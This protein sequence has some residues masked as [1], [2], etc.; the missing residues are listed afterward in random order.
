MDL[1]HVASILRGGTLPRQSRIL[2]VGFYCSICFI[3]LKNIYF[4]PLALS[5][6][7]ANGR[8]STLLLL[9]SNCLATYSTAI[10]IL[11]PSIVNL[12]MFEHWQT[13]RFLILS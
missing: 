3:V 5:K 6:I 8:C 11:A 1:N 13:H 9:V 2:T 4:F 10:T 7:Y 12:W